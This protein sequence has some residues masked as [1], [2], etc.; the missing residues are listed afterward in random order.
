M[1]L[2]LNDLLELDLPLNPHITGMSLDSH[3]VATGDVFF[4]I[5]G[6]YTH[7]EVYIDAALQRGAV[8]VVKE[9]TENQ[10]DVSVLVGL[11]GQIPCIAMPNL[12]QRLGSYAAKFYG[13]PTRDMQIIGVTGTNGKTSITHFIAQILQKLTQQPCGLLGTLGYGVYGK[14]QTGLHTTP[15][16]IRLQ[17]LF[18][19]LHDQSVKT[20]VMEVSSHGLVQGRANATHFDIAVFSNLTRD[21]LDYHGTMRAY[22]EAKQILFHF[23]EVA[24]AV[25]NADDE[26][27]Q[28][29]LQ[30]LPAR[31]RPL[32]YS[33]LHES[34]SVFAQFQ[35]LPSGYKLHISSIWGNG[36]FV[37]PLLGK[38]NIYNA[39]AALTVLLQLGLP[40]AQVLAVFAQVSPVAGRMET[41]IFPQQPMVIIDYAHTPDALQKVLLAVRQHYTGQLWCVFGCGGD[42][43]RGKRAL[44]GQIAQQY[45]DH[46]VLTDDNPRHEASEAIIRDISMG[47][48]HPTA[49]I[50]QREQAILYALSA[51]K[52]GDAVVIAGKGHED[53]QEI[54]GQRLPFSDKAV[55]TKWGLSRAKS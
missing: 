43:D 38:F 10:T 20:V 37:L 48:P 12:A 29:L 5:A 25:V 11:S 8:A 46:L 16:A 32:T 52:T 18:A 26:F 27:G 19:Q 31:V 53:Y 17:A 44:M 40:F 51:A 30:Q 42:R 13:Y 39:L 50:P 54:N 9:T 3:T 15:E 2:F 28:Q 33:L 47:C 6:R 41:L 4:A 45:A 24:A 22:G 55:V 7:G 49:I 36:E 21:H 23:P 14:L 1:S 35:P 34:S